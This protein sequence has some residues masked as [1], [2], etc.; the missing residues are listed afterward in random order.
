M[1]DRGDGSYTTTL[2]LTRTGRVTLSAVLTKV[3]GFYGEYFNNAFLDGAP[4]KT[5]VDAYL[6]FDW[7]TGMLTPEAADFVSIQWF[8]KIRPEYTEMYTFIVNADDGVRMYID[9]ELVIDRW[10]TC[11]EEMSH[12]MD[13]VKDD[14][15]DVKI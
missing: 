6:N 2:F 12:S 13:M 11:C 1:D 7:D 14:F 9:D 3:G 15:Y 8:G 10:D 4:T 5:Q